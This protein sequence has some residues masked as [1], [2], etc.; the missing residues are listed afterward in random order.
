MIRTHSGRLTWEKHLKLA[1]HCA[2][3]RKHL[4]AA[5]ELSKAGYGL[6]HVATVKLATMESELVWL[7]SL[8]AGYCYDEHRREENPYPQGTAVELAMRA[9]ELVE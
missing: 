7:E 5:M 2:E 4:L 8:L 3:I 1:E 9:T 6:R